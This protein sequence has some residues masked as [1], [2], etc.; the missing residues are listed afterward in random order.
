MLEVSVA[1]KEAQSLGC[2][3]LSEKVYIQFDVPSGIRPH[4][5]VR[6]QMLE[7]HDGECHKANL[8]FSAAI[9]K[10]F[11]CLGTTQAE[12]MLHTIIIVFLSCL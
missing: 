8:K 3:H 11:H 9:P 5:S 1:E 6:R 2:L 7:D 12:H 4:R 10:M